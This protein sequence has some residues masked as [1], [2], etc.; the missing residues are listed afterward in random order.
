[1][2]GRLGTGLLW[3]GDDL[4]EP[5]ERGLCEGGHEP[6]S[7]RQA[8]L[9]NFI[10]ADDPQDAVAR[11]APH[12]GYQ[13]SSYNRYGAEGRADGQTG[14]L[15]VSGGP[16]DVAALRQRH[17]PPMSPEYD[18]VSAEEAITRVRAWLEHRPVV[19]IFMWGSIAGMPDEIADRHAELV[20]SVVAPALADVGTAQSATEPAASGA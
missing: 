3:L 17:A 18:V 5:Y 10:V 2:A 1:M 14:A 15:T 12:I 20:A 16:V 4:I 19:D 11:V 13:R 8:G 7:G 9:V 6:G